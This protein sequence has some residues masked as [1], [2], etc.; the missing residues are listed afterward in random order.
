MEI[1]RKAVVN[2]GINPLTAITGLPN[3]ALVEEP[4]LGAVLTAAVAEA[5][6]VA[7]AMGYPIE[8]TAMVEQTMEVARRTGRNRSSMLQDIERGRRTEVDSITGVFVERGRAL[9]VPVPVSETLLALVHGIE[10][11]TASGGPGASG[12]ETKR[13]GPTILI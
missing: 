9:L 8:T 10:R 2:A 5:C 11:T 3:G 7:R 4:R 6:T 12:A 1:W 13:S